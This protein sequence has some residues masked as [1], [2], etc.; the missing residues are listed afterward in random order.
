MKIVKSTIGNAIRT[1]TL[2]NYI[3]GSPYIKA[4]PNNETFQHEYGHYLQSQSMGP[5]YLLAVGTV[6]VYS[7]LKND[8]WHNTQYVEIDADYRA[9]NYFNKYVSG[10]YKTYSQWLS[11]EACF[12]RDGNI[13]WNFKINPLSTIEGEYYDYNNELNM[14]KAKGKLSSFYL[15]FHF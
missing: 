9:F 6:S 12:E 14:E 5:L 10:F 1:A 3:I 4:D 8:N 2:G 7:A 15:F 13:G 11:N